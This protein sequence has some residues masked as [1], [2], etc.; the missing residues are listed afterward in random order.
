VSATGLRGS[1]GLVVVEA[2]LAAHGTSS[3]L[4]G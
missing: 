3:T 4:A 1:H 2:V